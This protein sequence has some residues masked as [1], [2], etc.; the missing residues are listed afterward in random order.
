MTTAPSTSAASPVAARA[1]GVIVLATLANLVAYASA[2]ANGGAPRWAAWLFAASTVAFMTAII[3]LGA[4][5]GPAGIGALRYPVALM[6]LLLLGGFAAALA[7]PPVTAGSPLWLGLPPA[8]AAVIYGV[9]LLPIVIL[10]VAYARTFDAL[11]LTDADLARVR[12]AGARHRARVA[13]QA[14]PD[15]GA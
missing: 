13:A 4:A 14:Q 2:F 11:T 5:R 8:A 9:G 1:R 12:E 10:P 6:A 7:L 3:V 15:G